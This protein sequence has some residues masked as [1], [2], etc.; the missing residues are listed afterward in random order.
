[1]LLMFMF[2][3]GWFDN[4]KSLSDETWLPEIDKKKKKPTKVAD[5]RFVE[6][7]LACFWFHE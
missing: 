1:M 2:V 4:Y 6:L 3:V 5:G 7:R